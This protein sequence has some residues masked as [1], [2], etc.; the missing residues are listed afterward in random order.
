M[1]NNNSLTYEIGIRTIVANGIIPAIE[2]TI[3]KD[4]TINNKIAEIA[5]LIVVYNK[6]FMD[7]ERKNYVEIN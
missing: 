1:I 6:F 4:E 7:G 3:N 2:K 5:N